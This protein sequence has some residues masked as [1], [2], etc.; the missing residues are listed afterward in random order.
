MPAEYRWGG[1]ALEYV[2]RQEI[3]RARTSGCLRKIEG[4]NDGK[5]TGVWLKIL[6][7]IW[8]TSQWESKR[9]PKYG[10]ASNQENYSHKIR[11]IV[12]DMVDEE[13]AEGQFGRGGRR[14]EC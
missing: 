7:Y 3:G 5:S 9:R 1:P 4:S 6:R 14:E 8:R 12:T 2:N 13:E 10:L 11:R